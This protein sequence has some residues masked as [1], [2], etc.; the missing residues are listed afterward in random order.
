MKQKKI[1]LAIICIVFLFLLGNYLRKTIYESF[2]DEGCNGDTYT[3][4][5]KLNSKGWCNKN[6]LHVTRNSICNYIGTY[7]VK[8]RVRFDDCLTKKKQDF[9]ESNCRDDNGNPY[10]LGY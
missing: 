9:C 1:V 4:C 3:N 6:C 2:V 7:G 5:I 10:P 8:R